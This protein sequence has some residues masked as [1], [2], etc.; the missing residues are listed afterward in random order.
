[1]QKMLGVENKS[2]EELNRLVKDR[3][4]LLKEA[5]IAEHAFNTVGEYTERNAK[6]A[7]DVGL[8]SKQM[9]RLTKLY[10]GR[11][12]SERNRSAY[13]GAVKEELGINGNL[14]KGITI[15]DVSSAIEKYIQNLSVI[16]DDYPKS[17]RT[18]R[19]NNNYSDDTSTR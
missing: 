1:M 17:W 2:Q 10:A 16:S 12:T 9:D 14:N 19:K 15:S 13:Q 18:F 4:T 6:L 5:A 3:V 11:N 8:N 7:A